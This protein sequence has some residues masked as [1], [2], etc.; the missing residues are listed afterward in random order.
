MAADRLAAALL[1]FLGLASCGP[2]PLVTS[3]AP[4]PVA[5]E[6][7]PAPAR[8]AAS[9]D[10]EAYY[11]RVEGSLR[12]QGL[13][14]TDAAP[15][16]AP[17]DAAKLAQTFE[18]VAL[19]EEYSTIG[20]RLVARESAST[21]HR[22]DGPIR[23]KVEFGQTVE[24]EKRQRDQAAINAYLFRLSGLIGRP[25][26]Q[27][28]G[29]GANFHV[30]VVNEDERRALGPTLRS[31]VPSISDAALNTV[32]DLE[33]PSYCLVLAWDND[34]NGAYERAVAVI[35]GEHPDLLRLSCIHEEIAQG[36]GLSN[37]SPGARPS[38]FNDDEEFALLTDH[39]ALL[40]R[41]LYDPALRPG[42]TLDEARPI[43]RTLAERVLP[44]GG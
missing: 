13:L 21:L 6:V 39:D 24:P 30:F 25:I 1:C 41:M 5:P 16:D 27:V 3:P 20:G 38:V 17:F 35:R 44:E 2:E 29:N 26:R 11:A 42:M 31:I 18:Q 22:W 15:T 33:R 12:Q 34:L 32:T 23:V 43:I 40:L 7:A 14:R 37:D 36:L 10:L 9:L 28:R 4:A 19:F 8:S